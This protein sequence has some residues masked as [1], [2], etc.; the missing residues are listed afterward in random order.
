MIIFEFIRKIIL[1]AR[2]IASGDHQD[3]F[4]ISESIYPSGNPTTSQGKEN[5]GPREQFFKDSE[6]YTSKLLSVKC[7]GPKN[8]AP[9]TCAN[10]I[11]IRRCMY[12]QLKIL[13]PV[14]V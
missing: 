11:Y 2:L 7:K 4:T 6:V 1:N 9:T 14:T 5:P 12:T 13:A 10:I 8:R 3:I